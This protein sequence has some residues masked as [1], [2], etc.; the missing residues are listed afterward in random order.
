VKG[1]EKMEGSSLASYVSDAMSAITTLFTF[2]TTNA[3]LAA[4]AIGFP[5]VRV[6]AGALKRLI[7]V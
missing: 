7:R 2:I 1:G 6:G 3:A 4:I 5:V